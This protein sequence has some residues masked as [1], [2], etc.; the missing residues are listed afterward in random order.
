MAN[1][2]LFPVGSVVHFI[3]RR[4]RYVVTNSTTLHGM[5]LVAL[6]GA[7]SG[8]APSG[9]YNGVELD[10]DQKVSFSGKIASKLEDRAG[11]NRRNLAQSTT[12]AANKPLSD[13]IRAEKIAEGSS[14][15]FIRQ[16]DGV[17]YRVT[18]ERI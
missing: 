2:V 14:V 11:W 18:L 16:V 8:S 7:E 15:S 10:A 5:N 4:R 6:S 1:R 9:V 3:G 12:E 17:S 13:I